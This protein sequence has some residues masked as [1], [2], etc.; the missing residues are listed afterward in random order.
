MPMRPHAIALSIL[1]SQYRV[2]QFNAAYGDCL[3]RGDFDAYIGIWSGR[4]DPDGNVS[5]WLAC[6]G[7]L[8]RGKYCNP[9]LDRVLEAARQTT[10]IDRRVALYR[11]ASDIYLEDRPHMVLYHL[12]WLW[13]VRDA[14]SGFTG[15]PDGLIRP[16]DIRLR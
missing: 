5:I 9:A 11:Q 10:D 7:F 12:R 14:V 6:D 15:H 2:D 4:A 1:E 3:D 8:N 13:A 16:Q